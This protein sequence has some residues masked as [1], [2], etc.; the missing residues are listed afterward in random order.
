[1][2][3]PPQGRVLRLCTWCVEAGYVEEECKPGY[4]LGKRSEGKKARPALSGC[5]CEAG[6][7]LL[8]IAACKE[9]KGWQELG[10]L[11][12]SKCC[13][14]NRQ[15]SLP[16]ADSLGRVMRGPGRQTPFAP[17]GWPLH[18]LFSTFAHMCSTS[19]LQRTII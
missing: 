6:H 16:I 9:R 15:S 10:L 13:L 1:M 8:R 19:A 3:I 18:F 2:G 11:D 17:Q 12:K 5:K 7:G 4:L 14:V